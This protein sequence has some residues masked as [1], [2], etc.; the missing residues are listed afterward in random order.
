MNVS[1]TPKMAQMSIYVALAGVSTFQPAPSGEKIHGFW[2]YFLYLSLTGFIRRP[3]YHFLGLLHALSQLNQKT[4]LNFR[5]GPVAY[6]T[7]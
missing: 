2:R 6:D 5:I 4:S 1:G 7:M 3:I